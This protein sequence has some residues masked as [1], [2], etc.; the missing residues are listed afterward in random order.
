MNSNFIIKKKVSGGYLLDENQWSVKHLVKV[1][2]SVFC[3]SDENH[4]KSKPM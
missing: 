2:L 3:I 1:I 4:W